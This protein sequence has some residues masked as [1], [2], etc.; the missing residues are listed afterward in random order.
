MDMQAKIAA[1]RAELENQTRENNRLVAEHAQAQRKQALTEIAS[2]VSKEGLEVHRQGDK[3]VTSKVERAPLD[4]DGLKR[5]AID[6]LLSEEARKIWTP[7]E[8]VQVIAMIVAGVFLIAFY[9]LGLVLIVIGLLAR[10]GL[11][12]RY[13]AEL[14]R[15]YP[16]VFPISEIEAR[17]PAP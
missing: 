8:N 7:A 12:K 9:G 16:T 4:F 10:N 3:L 6:K 1:R 17:A 5:S 15:R 14:R 13:K 11:N 2:E